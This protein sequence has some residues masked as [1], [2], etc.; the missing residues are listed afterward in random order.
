[1]ATVEQL[2]KLRLFIDDPAGNDQ[3]FDDPDLGAFIT[4][5]GDDLSQ[6][7]SELWKVKAAR[8][9]EW[10]TVNM[11]GNFMSRDQVFAHCLKMS[12]SYANSGSM[13]NVALTTL[14]V[15][16]GSRTPEY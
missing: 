9:S 2:A 15:D 7:A 11:D 12:E 13:T 16:S 3:L 14:S 5:A 6:A 8:V 4:D 1:M 10:Y